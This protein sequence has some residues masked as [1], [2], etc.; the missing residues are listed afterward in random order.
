MIQYIHTFATMSTKP[1]NTPESSEAPEKVV[2]NEEIEELVMPLHYDEELEK[3]LR[4]NGFIRDDFEGNV[5]DVPF[6]QSTAAEAIKS[7]EAIEADKSAEAIKSSEAIEAAE[8]AKSAEAAKAAK[9]AKAA[10]IEASIAAEDNV[11]G[12][13]LNPY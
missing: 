8:A 10:A 4:E 5:A 3:Y 2:H 1:D 9:V 6:I 11:W 12:E 7:S 13:P